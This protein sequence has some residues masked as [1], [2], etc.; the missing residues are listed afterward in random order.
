ME[1]ETDAPGSADSPAST[2]KVSTEVVR[3]NA[4]PVMTD[5]AKGLA[6]VLEAS[7]L[8]GASI[9]MR[10]MDHI[11]VTGE[12]SHLSE[13]ELEDFVEVVD[14]DPVRHVAMAIGQRDAPRTIPLMWL[15]LRVYPGAEGVAVLPQHEAGEPLGLRPAP[16]GSFDE[17]FAVGEQMA[18]SGREGILGP[19][20][21]TFE[22]V[23][24]LVVVPP[25]ANPLTV[26]RLAER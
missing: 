4:V 15:L 7:S 17:A 20:V 25:N 8:E 1:Q 6:D 21:G 9:A 3:S 2:I 10:Q 12:G 5:W 11:V 13:L 18:G 16:R 26:L 22:R 19:A 23:G 24:T 14:Y